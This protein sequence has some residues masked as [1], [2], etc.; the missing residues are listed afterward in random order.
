M[1]LFSFLASLTGIFGRDG[2][3][4]AA[5]EADHAGTNHFEVVLA[6]GDEGDNT[7]QDT[8]SDYGPTYG[9]NQAYAAYVGEDHGYYYAG[10]NEDL[11]PLPS[12]A[13]GD[14]HAVLV[15]LSD[16]GAMLDSAISHLDASTAPLDQGDLDLPHSFDTPD[17]HTGTA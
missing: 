11:S 6:P 15:S 3:D 17:H 10:G 5:K 14:L 4:S 12:D 13:T 1:V 9:H 16:T 7:R 8:G 2:S